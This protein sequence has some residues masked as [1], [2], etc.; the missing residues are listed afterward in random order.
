MKEKDLSLKLRRGFWLIRASQQNLEIILRLQPWASSAHEIQTSV[1]S[2]AVVFC[3]LIPVLLQSSTPNLHIPT[4]GAWEMP[5]KLFFFSIAA[6]LTK[7]FSKD[8][9]NYEGLQV[10]SLLQ[11]IW[12]EPTRT[13][14]RKKACYSLLDQISLSQLGSSTEQAFPYNCPGGS[15][16]HQPRESECSV[17][18]YSP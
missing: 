11:Q 14:G 6:V 7:I 2:T 18:F 10:A 12:M 4:L 17:W 1:W 16:H 15:L 8:L 13:K 3:G 5:A 9:I